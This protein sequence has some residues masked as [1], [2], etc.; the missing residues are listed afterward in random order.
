MDDGD[1]V[2]VK[3]AAVHFEMELICA[4]G[5]DV[6]KS[7]ELDGGVLRDLAASGG[8]GGE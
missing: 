4:G 1:F 3:V 6:E 2:E 8:K 5:F 7:G